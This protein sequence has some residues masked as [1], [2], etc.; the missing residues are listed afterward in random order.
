MSPVSQIGDRETNEIN[1]NLLAEVSHLRREVERLKQ[2]NSDLRLSL[3]TVTEHGDIIEAELN[4]ANRRLQAEITERQLAQ[5]TLQEILETVSRDKAELEMILQTTTAHGDALEYEFYTQ[6]VETMR[7]SEELFRAIS[8]STS[9]LMILTQ[10]ADGAITYANLAS[11]EQLGL[12]R[13]DLLGQELQAFLADPSDYERM[14]ELLLCQGWVR[15]FEL[16]IRRAD[17]NLAWVAAALN[18]L[19]LGG[20]A[21][22]LI[23]L[24]D[25]SER[26]CNE[27]DRQR[28]EQA[29]R[30][31]EEKLRQQAID[32]EQRV[33]QRTVELQQAE[34]KYRSIF[35]N[36][37]EGIF[38]TS[39]DGRYLN[40]NP[41]LAKLYG[42]ESPQELIDS[43]T[44]IGS[45]IYVQPRRR[46][47]L[48]AYLSRFEFAEGFESEVYR[49]DG[50]TIW[51]SEDVRTIR[52]QTGQVLRYEGSIRDITD[53]K[54]TEE[55]LRRQRLRA[56]RLLLNVLPQ[57]IAE[58]LKRNETTIADS[59]ANVSVLFADIAGFTQLAATTNPAAVVE[60]L[61]AIFSA[62]D[63]LSDR[64]G[65]E[66]IKTIGDSYMVVGGLPKIQ[67]D[68]EAAIAN[69]ALDMLEV[70]KTFKTPG[71]QPIALR[72]GINVGPVVAGVIGT[73]KFTYDIWGD[74]VN[75][76]NRMEYHGEEGRIQVTEVIYERLR[77]RFEFQRRGLIE[78]KGK[79]QM[80]TY[81]LVGRKAKS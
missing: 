29:L 7:Q 14:Q 81:W 62:F 31:S 6:A 69:M 22:M 28:I 59:F 42:Y 46:D 44:D 41:A 40:A 47:E 60:L 38:Q 49:K 57:R 21:I 37:T 17:G 16:Q 72:I 74:T 45:Q 52:D 67:A 11:S 25:I 53:L 32:L 2:A 4:E 1:R 80:P 51:I 36:A 65:L 75:T 13:Q 30:E 35:E 64:Y 68:H 63:Q 79:G 15:D 55:E 76:A 39:P 12:S 58:R 61:N 66:K 77:D 73:R 10:R 54:T 33:I 3:T 27:A 78:V 20:Q 71:Q 26:K 24:Y 19:Q 9:V 70:I 5:N 23:T 34:E 56:E 50:S 8:E 48:L 18:P 43:I